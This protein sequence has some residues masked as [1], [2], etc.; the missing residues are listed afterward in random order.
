MDRSKK[1]S[2]VSVLSVSSVVNFSVYTSSNAVNIAVSWLIAI[3]CCPVSHAVPR[4]GWDTQLPVFATVTEEKRP[5]FTKFKK[6]FPTV[7]VCGAFVAFC[8]CLWH[9]VLH[10]AT[11]RIAHFGVNAVYT[12]DSNFQLCP[13]VP[14]ISHTQRSKKGTVTRLAFSKTKV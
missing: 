3:S 7:A 12:I 6:L 10:L 9:F 2:S 4:A 5:F 14:A 1:I 13:T 11:C 8:G